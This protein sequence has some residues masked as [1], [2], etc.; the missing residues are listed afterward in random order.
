MYIFILIYRRT[1]EAYRDQ[2]RVDA[3]HGRWRSPPLWV[4]E[5]AEEGGTGAFAIKT[6]SWWVDG[7]HGR[8]SPP[9]PPPIWVQEEAAEGGTGAFAI[10]TASWR[11]DGGHGRLSPPLPPPIWVQEEA[12]EG[13]TGPLAIKA[14]YLRLLSTLA[15]L[16]RAVVRMNQTEIEEETQTQLMTLLNNSML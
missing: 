13:G 7:G 1:E 11:V 5:E 2:L 8:W 16:T 10:K 15:P 14:S 6:A 9:L 12:A 3:E 4:L